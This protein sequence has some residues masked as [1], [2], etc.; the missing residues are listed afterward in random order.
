MTDDEL[1]EKIEDYVSGSMDLEMM[2][3]WIVEDIAHWPKDE[4]LDLIGVND[5]EEETR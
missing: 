2:F 3:K 5:E 1:R 4:I